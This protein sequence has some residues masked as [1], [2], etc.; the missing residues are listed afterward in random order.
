M[1]IS[2]KYKFIFIKTHKTASSSVCVDLGSKCA[3]TDIV[4]PVN[5]FLEEDEVIKKHIPRNYTKYKKHMRIK[6][7]KRVLNNFKIFDSYFKFCVEREPIDK[8]LSHFYWHHR[9][10]LD[11]FFYKEVDF[12]W[13]KFIFSLPQINN[14]NLNHW[15][16]DGELAVDKI[17]RY[18]NLK[19]ELTQTCKQLGM[20][21]ELTTKA[22]V[23]LRKNKALP[24]PN[25]TNKQIEQVYEN[26]KISN[27]FTGY[28]IEDC[29]YYEN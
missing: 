25:I 20:E 22:K 8:L 3:P 5:E 6:A 9:F 17:L 26:W 28:K 16:I 7:I 21:V 12:L 24:K 19:E 4:L 23:S 2:H 29:K 15:T 11:S 18:E 14:I 1:I 13:E 10:K 27:S